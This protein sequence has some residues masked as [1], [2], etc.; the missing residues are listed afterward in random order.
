QPPEAERNPVRH[1]GRTDSEGTTLSRRSRGADR[2]RNL[3]ETCGGDHEGTLQ[4][5]L[6]VVDQIRE[7]PRQQRHGEDLLHAARELEQ[8]DRLA[9]AQVHDTDAARPLLGGQPLGDRDAAED[10][11]L[12]HLRQPDEGEIAHEVEAAR[13]PR[14]GGDRLIAPGVPVHGAERPRARLADP[15]PAAVPA[16]RVGHR[17]ARQRMAPES[18][19]IR[20]PPR[21]L[22]ARRPAIVFVSPSAVTYFGLPSTLPRPLRWQRSD[23]ASSVTNGGRQRGVKLASGSSVARQEKRVLT[24]QNW[25]PAP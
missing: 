10:R 14:H 25:P 19:S 11:R 23:G 2:R 18:T 16:R 22:F 7:P 3:T 1:R 12:T 5:L 15:Q 24:N 20:T 9:A 17:Q 21:A 8:G 4:Q 6:A 13:E